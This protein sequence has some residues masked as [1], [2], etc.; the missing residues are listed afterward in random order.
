MLP[1]AVNFVNESQ[2]IMFESIVCNAHDQKIILRLRNIKPNYM[3]IKR[4]IYFIITLKLYFSIL[5]FTN[6]FC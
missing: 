2:T 4:N 6:T 5:T 3:C 1:F